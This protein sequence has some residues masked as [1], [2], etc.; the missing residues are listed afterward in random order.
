MSNEELSAAIRGLEI[1]WE[2][3]GSTASAQLAPGLPAEEPRTQLS[4]LGYQASDEMVTWWGWQ[5]GKPRML[6]L[7]EESTN[8]MVK[9]GYRVPGF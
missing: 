8:I 7:L 6:V 5:N 3:A 2:A 9:T 4:E 1:A